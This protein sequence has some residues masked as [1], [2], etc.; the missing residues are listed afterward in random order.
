MGAQL[1][2]S[3]GAGIYEEILFRGLVLGGL[4][5]GLGLF[6]G[7]SAAVRE[8]AAAVVASTL[9]SAYHYLGPFGDPFTIA[10]FTFR[11]F[12]GVVFSGLLV[13]R[14]FGV[15]VLT[16]ALYDVLVTLGL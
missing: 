10:S 9:F 4:R 3:L 14:G 5:F 12:F 11:L 16:H 15:T 2:L 7:V 8:V 1:I 6:S 13:A